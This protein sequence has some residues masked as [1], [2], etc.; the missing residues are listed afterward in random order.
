MT[1]QQPTLIPSRATYRPGEAIDIELEGAD[2]ADG[3]LSVWRL[4][5]LVLEQPLQPGA[6]QSLAPLPKGGYGLEVQ[7]A[8]GLV[9]TAIE[10]TDSP[11]SRLRYGFVAAY[12]PGKDVDGVVRL[13]RRLHLNGIQFYDWA[14]RHADL[15]GGGDVFDDA[16]GQ[17]VDLATVKRLIDALRGAGSVAHGYAAVYAVGPGEWDEW[18]DLA[19]LRGDGEPYA[20]GDFLFLVDP[21]EPRWAGHFAGELQ[22]AASRLG[23][24]GFHLDQY[25]YPKHAATPQGR[26][27][28]VGESFVS[29]LDTL[30][31]AL[32]S[33]SLVFNNVNDF[34]TWRTASSPQDAVYIEPWKPNLDLGSLAAVVDRARASAGGLP[35]VLAA[36]QHVYDSVAAAEADRAAALTMATLFSHGATQLLAGETNHVL[37]D[38]YYV[39]NH[40]AEPGTIQ[41]LSRWYDFLV[42]HDDLLLHPAI[43]EVT[44]SYVGDYNDDLD[45]GFPRSGAE[46]TE[47]PVAGA[48]WRRVTSTPHGLVVHAINLVGQTDTL[49][50]APRQEPT[51]VGEG[52]LRF[53]HVHGRLP[54]VRVADPDR[55]PRLV[56]VP[57][58]IDG[59]HAVASL[60]APHL[61]QVIHVAL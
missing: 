50:D 26:L 51:D 32:P 34:P 15:L 28:D 16:L 55:H 40:E 24:E 47:L 33:A 19:L 10:V 44:R 11:R 29:L 21:A 25:G 57:V 1:V 38:P 18:R 53:R 31:E 52:E 4:G 59:D 6:W 20:L 2:G 60:P 8:R 23:F 45:L 54:S 9:R 13:A 17:P 56:D 49:W 37:V 7:T 30:R 27:V 36:Y 12:R 41:L 46:V 14:Y 5:R 39:R 3:V 58:R 48:V 35:V 43:A 61:W 22:N 42:E